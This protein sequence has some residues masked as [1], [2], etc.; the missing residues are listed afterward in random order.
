MARRTKRDQIGECIHGFPV[1]PELKSGDNMMDTHPIF[2]EATHAADVLVALKGFVSLGVPIGTVVTI[3]SALPAMVLFTAMICPEALAATE[4]VSAVSSGETCEGLSAMLTGKGDFLANVK[5]TFLSYSLA[6]TLL[7]T[8][9]LWAMCLPFGRIGGRKLLPAVIADIHNLFG[10]F[11]SCCTGTLVRAILS[12]PVGFVK[13]DLAAG[14][15]DILDARDAY[16]EATEDTAALGRATLLVG[17]PVYT[18]PVI[19]WLV[20]DRTNRGKCVLHH[21]S[22]GMNRSNKRGTFLGTNA[23]RQAATLPKPHVKYI[24]ERVFCK[25]GHIV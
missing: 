4:M 18:R 17:N 10:R 5:T 20:A 15:A 6:L 7:G 8:K 1:L 25:G 21:T 14:K 19:E 23:C 3:C 16:L 2:R 24:T 11:L 22:D 9:A 13:E 12:V